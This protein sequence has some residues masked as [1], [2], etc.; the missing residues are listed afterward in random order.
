VSKRDLVDS[1]DSEQDSTGL[2]TGQP[3]LSV[4]AR[5]RGVLFV[6]GGPRAGTIYPLDEPVIN[7]GRSPSCQIPLLDEGVS[8][9]HARIMHTEDG[10]IL[11]DAGS[12]N[13]TYCQGRR[14]LGPRKLQEG[15]RINLGA[16][17]AFRFSAQDR[18]EFHA[19]RQTLEL[20]IHD[21]LTDLLNRRELDER[22][23]AELAYACRHGSPLSVLL[24]DIDH[25]KDI[26]DAYGHLTGDMVLRDVAA[27][28]AAELR[29]ED[30]F[31]RF[32]G[33][34]FALAVRGI[35][36]TGV[37]AL[38]ERLRS[39]VEELQVNARGEDLEI[40]ISIG[41]AMLLPRH[42]DVASL[43]HE[44]NAALY[45]AKKRGRNRVVVY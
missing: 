43:V 21:P 1:V 31:G 42:E 36:Y 16:T 33:D 2:M 14:L 35:E 22:F 18:A 45:E 39:C 30:V 15:D 17:T 25:F 7:L 20:M 4:G 11:E 34:E 6:L 13:G 32:G 29:V 19:I 5:D 8:R 41:G 10:F 38:A 37:A 24:V 28:L 12:R 23:V 3:E 26:N 9:L 40:T 44:A 27:A